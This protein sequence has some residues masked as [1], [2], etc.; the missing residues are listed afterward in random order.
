MKIE[1]EAT[2]LNVDK[3]DVRKRLK[4]AG[5]RILRPEFLQRRI[6]LYPPIKGLPANS[7]LR[8]RDE[9]NKIT[10]SLKASDGDKIHDQK[11]TYI[12]V[13][14]FDETV[15]FLETIGCIRKN[16][17]ETK[18]ELWE[19][20]GAEI[21]IDEW[22]FLE[23]FVEVEGKSEEEVKRVSEKLGFNYKDALFCAVT[24]V[25]HMK[26]GIEPDR[27]NIEPKLVFDMENPFTR[28]GR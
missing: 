8:V 2:F 11:E 14:D 19:L 5:A 20:D 25:Y 27:I 26:Y 4:K 1:Y 9:G 6:N 22:P 16:Y 7:W 17:Q 18:R 3:D 15:E 21:T 24:N 10:L 12:E 23:P 13:N 28:A